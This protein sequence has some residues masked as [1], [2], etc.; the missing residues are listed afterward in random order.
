MTRGTELA[1]H[2]TLGAIF[3]T[4]SADGVQTR[5]MGNNG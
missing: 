5:R 2:N 3:D 1:Y 4:G